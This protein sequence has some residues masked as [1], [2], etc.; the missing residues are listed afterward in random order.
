MHRPFLDTFSFRKLGFRNDLRSEYVQRILT[1]ARSLVQAWPSDIT[2]RPKDTSVEDGCVALNIPLHSYDETHRQRLTEYIEKIV[3]QVDLLLRIPIWE[4]PLRLSAVVQ[5]AKQ[6]PD[7]WPSLL[8]LALDTCP[9]QSTHSDVALDPALDARCLAY[10]IDSADLGRHRRQRAKQILA[11]TEPYVTLPITAGDLQA[12]RTCPYDTLHQARFGDQHRFHPALNRKVLFRA[13]LS[14]EEIRQWEGQLGRD[15][16]TETAICDSYLPAH[17]LRDHG[18]RH[19]FSRLPL[20]GAPV[21]CYL[22]GHGCDSKAHCSVA[23]L[24]AVRLEEEYRKRV[25][26]YEERD[27]PFPVAGQEVRRAV[28]AHA[29]HQ[30]HSYPGTHKID[31]DLPLHNGQERGLSSCA[32]CAMMFWKEDLEEFELFDPRPAEGSTNGPRP[33]LDE[34]YDG[35]DGEVQRGSAQVHGTSV[36]HPWATASDGTAC[37]WI[38]DTTAIPVSMDGGPGL[39][40]DNTLQPDSEGRFPSIPTCLSCRLD[41]SKKTPLLPRYALANDNLILRE[42]VAFRKNG[43]KLSPM[44]FAMLA[45]ARMLVRKIIAEKTK[46]ADPRAKQK[47]LRSNSIC[48]PQAYAKELATQALPAEHEVSQQ[49]FADGLSIALAGASVDDLDKATLATHSTLTRMKP[50]DD[51]KKQDTAAQRFS[52]KPPA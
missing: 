29:R 4:Q 7:V 24:E 9:L 2:T 1:A 34:D 10:D 5:W 48:F 23:G 44:T 8:Q 21:A 15:I 14:E 40:P 12:L 32:V 35:D 17:L 33:D 28:S 30:T 27:G 52:N 36:V 49:F 6:H 38:L 37:R 3:H 46:K 42:P 39:L 16:W 25:F 31:H 51:S 47:G 22:C 20:C 50:H 26:Y 18:T 19:S 43:A 45:L 11:D 13:Q 41:L